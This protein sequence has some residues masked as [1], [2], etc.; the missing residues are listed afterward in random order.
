MLAI[1]YILEANSDGCKVLG[2]VD[3]SPHIYFRVLRL[4]PSLC[5]LFKLL[6]ISGLTNICGRP[7]R[8]G[9][10]ASMACIGPEWYRIAKDRTRDPRSGI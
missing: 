4:D 7:V 8:F 6:H 10:S 3:T 5:K 1:I 2:P 9:K